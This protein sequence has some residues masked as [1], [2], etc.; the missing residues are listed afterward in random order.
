[1][2]R[3]YKRNK[4]VG[5]INN[6]KYQLFTLC[7][8]TYSVVK[9]TVIM[10]IKNYNVNITYKKKPEFISKRAKMIYASL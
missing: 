9:H 8:F 7:Y 5:R 4:N 2:D 3:I 1:M 10:K 6:G